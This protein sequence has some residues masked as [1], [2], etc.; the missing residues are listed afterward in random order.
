M[1]APRNPSADMD[2]DYAWAVG[3]HWLT[4]GDDEL[5]VDRIPARPHCGGGAEAEPVFEDA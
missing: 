4:D 3:D 2:P 1:S 5:D